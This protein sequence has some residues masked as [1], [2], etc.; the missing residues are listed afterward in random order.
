MFDKKLS[1]EEKALRGIVL[2]AALCFALF[3]LPL[4]AA[5]RPGN[6]GY[7]LLQEGTV[8]NTFICIKHV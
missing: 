8:Y 7:G 4:T 6:A 1:T 3:R 2:I 5:A